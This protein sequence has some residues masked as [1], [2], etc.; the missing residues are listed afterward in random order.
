MNAED[1]HLARLVAI[2]DSVTPCNAGCDLSIVLAWV[3]PADRQ[4]MRELRSRTERERDD[5]LRLAQD[6]VASIKRLPHVTGLAIEAERRL[7]NLTDQ[8]AVP[9]RAIARCAQCGRRHELRPS[10]AEPEEATCG[11]LGCP[12]CQRS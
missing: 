3:D 9:E 2:L 4:R 7:A 6:L 12:A 11:L 5:A 8:R 1:D 10:D